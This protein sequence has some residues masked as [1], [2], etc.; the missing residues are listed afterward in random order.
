M[1]IVVPVRTRGRLVSHVARA[2]VKKEP[3]YHVPRSGKRG[4]RNG[5]ALF[6]EPALREELGVVIP[7]EG[8][9]KHLRL[10][11]AGAP[12]PVAVLGAQ[13][14]GPFKLA[15]LSAFP[16]VLV[17]ADPDAAGDSLFEA[18]RRGVGRASTVERL[19]LDLA[20]DDTTVPVLRA[21]LRRAGAI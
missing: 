10:E 11:L 2:F 4:A 3:R 15:V 20:P 8:V 18:I 21:A 16:R 1:R 19:D 9:F 13:N 17:A 14:L 6:G 5:E 12:N 7:C